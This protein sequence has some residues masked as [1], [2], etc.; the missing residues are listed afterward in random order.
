MA[1]QQNLNYY[2]YNGSEKTIDDYLKENNAP[3]R[4]KTLECEVVRFVNN[5]EKWIGFLGIYEQKD[6]DIKFPYEL[7]TGVFVHDFRP[8]GISMC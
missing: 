3:K 2:H 6:P 1:I 4:P 5:K 8:S 7:F